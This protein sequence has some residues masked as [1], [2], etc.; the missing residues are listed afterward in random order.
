[1]IWITGDI[2]GDPSRFSTDCFYEQK[3]MTKDDYVIICGDF[4]V[5]WNEKDTKSSDWWLN[6]LDDRP[7]TTL[8]VD[9]NHENFNMINKLPV[10]EWHGGKVHEVCPSVL[11]LMRGEIFDICG[12]KI[13]AFGGASSHDIS[14][15]ILDASDPD[16]KD[17]AKELNRRGKYMYRVKDLSWWEEEMPSKDEMDHGINNLIQHGWKV[18]YIVTHSPAASNLAEIGM[19]MY[20]QDV[21]TKY[22]ESIKQYT[23]YDAHFMGHMHINERLNDKDIVL[24]DQIIRAA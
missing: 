24:Y 11:H 19:G 8:F 21:L 3:E 5:L 22:L 1:M 14:D 6:W 7:F 20:E 23:E 12:K 18:D 16:W 2:H 9:G 10:K 13:F 17:K 15:G 4:G